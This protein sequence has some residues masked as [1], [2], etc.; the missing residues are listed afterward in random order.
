VESIQAIV[1]TE[2]P[3]YPWALDKGKLVRILEGP[4]TGSIGRILRQQEKKRRLVVA[5]ELF[6]RSVAVELEDEAVEPYS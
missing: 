6:Q 5:V 4:L 2:R 3:Y 1:E